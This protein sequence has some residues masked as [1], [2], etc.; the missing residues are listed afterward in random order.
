MVFR[1][2]G[3]GLAGATVAYAL[4]RAGR[5]VEV[6]EADPTWGGQLRT[7]RA[8]GVYY[9][10][11]GAHIFHTRDSEVWRLVSGL[12]PM[13]PY[14]HRVRTRVFGTTLSWPPQLGELRALPA[15]PR[16]RP[17][18]AGPAVGPGPGELRVL[19]RRT[20]GRDA[21]RRVHRRVHEET[22]GHRATEPGRRLGPEA[23]RAA[24]RRTGSPT[25]SATRT[26]AGRRAGTPGWSTRCCG[27]YPSRWGGG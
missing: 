17:G 10:P 21:V 6:I 24:R 7:A 3:G 5:S 25:C 13:L 23:D 20:D 26:R 12:V 27:T 11:T 22:V 2:V 18:A 8:G 19:V 15:W 4:A 1:V 16:D 14:R 9:E